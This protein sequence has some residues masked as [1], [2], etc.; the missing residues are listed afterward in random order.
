MR[1]TLMRCCT[2][3]GRVSELV[4]NPGLQDTENTIP[5]GLNE[6]EICPHQ[7]QKLHFLCFRKELDLGI[8]ML[9]RGLILHLSASPC[10]AF[11]L[12]QFLSKR[13]PLQTGPIPISSPGEGKN[14]F[15]PG[16]KHRFC[17]GLSLDWSG[18][19][20]YA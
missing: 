10:V 15:L 17:S 1:S 14:Q 7:K 8:E 13:R 18:S 9:P 19:H 20:D 4:R 12:E 11:P 2:G 16:F 5:R 3:L 6:K